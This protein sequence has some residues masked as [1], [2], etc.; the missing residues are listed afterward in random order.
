MSNKSE[1]N[2]PYLNF[3][4]VKLFLDVAVYHKP[5]TVHPM[6]SFRT[7]SSPDPKPLPGSQLLLR[8]KELSSP[9]VL[10][11]CVDV[12]LSVSVVV[13]C[14]KVSLS[15]TRTVLCSETRLSFG[16]TVLGTG[17]EG[18]FSETRVSYGSQ[19]ISIKVSLVIFTGNTCVLTLLPL[20]GD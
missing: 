16:V 15:E 20:S 2:V 4:L 8:G 10:P 1:V 3:G 19:E 13:R 6:S 12:L 7:S 18:S 14:P 17:C 9:P 11:R 5:S